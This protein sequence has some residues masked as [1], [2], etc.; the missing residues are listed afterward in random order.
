MWV[1]L[2]QHAITSSFHFLIRHPRMD[3][4]GG[5]P[6][7]PSRSDIYIRQPLLEVG[8]DPSPLLFPSATSFFAEFA[9]KSEQFLSTGL[10]YHTLLTVLLAQYTQ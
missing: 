7:G 10:M 9:N 4:H 1:P 3:R 5:T 2:L 8:N 6:Q